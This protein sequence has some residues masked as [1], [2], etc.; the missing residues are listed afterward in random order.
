M[1]K[2][3][4]NA[5]QGINTDS[6]IRRGFEIYDEWSDKKLSSR[7]IVA[8]VQNEVKLLR[9]KRKNIDAFI[10]AL[11]Y[12]FALDTR[13]KERYN[14]VLR[15]LF[16]FFSWRR[17][18]RALEFLKSALN[19]P[20]GTA[21]IRDAIAVELENLGE[22]LE[23]EW[24]EDGDDDTRGGKRNGKP[25]DADAAEEKQAEETAEK[26]PEE[27]ELSDK[28]ETKEESEREEEKS[29]DEKTQESK[30]EIGKENEADEPQQE[31]TEENALDEKELVQDENE[32]LKE[33]ND[34][35]KENEESSKDKKSQEK[36]QDGAIDIPVII[37]EAESTKSD[38]ISFLDE[39][40]LDRIA[41]CMKISDAIR[42]DGVANPTQDNSRTED[43]AP[44]TDNENKASEKDSRLD[45][46][47]I[48][49]NKNGM[50]NEA[51]NTPDQ[52]SEQKTDQKTEQITSKTEEK[53]TAQ[54]T[55]QPAEQKT[56][57][58][59]NNTNLTDQNKEDRVPVKVDIDADQ[60]NAVAA[61]LNESMSL[62]SKM[63][64]IE[65]QMDMMREQIRI[66]S[67]EVGID[68]PVPTMSIKNPEPPVVNQPTVAPNIKK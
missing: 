24:D 28:E 2:D 34:G 11:A 68:A 15:C 54:T 42:F 49:M 38:K 45:E 62:E 18:T 19:I 53:P 27:E 52:A 65:M 10:N 51:E 67:E 64:Y 58:N 29:I 48:D 59:A 55:E 39:I 25:G 13:I 60:L 31:Q 7:Q 40:I 16:S 21:D 17:E 44:K 8:S 5:Y 37:E 6:V 4:D 47:F 30:E 35:T 22:K 9:K 12:L 63:D 23:N 36:N 61:Q 14:T 41:R 56:E 33:E 46:R 57:Q 66:A 32:E 50:T 3:F 1:K 43:N 20:L 26:N